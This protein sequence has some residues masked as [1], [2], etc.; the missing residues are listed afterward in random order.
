MSDI[1]ITAGP[2]LFTARLETADAPRTCEAILRQ[3]PLTGHLLHVRWS[4]EAAWVPLGA[5]SLG[6][7]PENAVTYPLP[8]QVL[9]YPGPISET[10]I[11]L[12]YGPTHFASKAGSLAGNHFLTMTSGTEQLRELGQQVLWKGAQPFSM[13]RK[14]CS[15]PR[16]AV[17]PIQDMR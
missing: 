3:L 6:L 15:T 4:G 13:A 17:A 12:P 1:L 14:G 9:L 5:L 7:P 8:G 16:C 2:F 11:L 10:E